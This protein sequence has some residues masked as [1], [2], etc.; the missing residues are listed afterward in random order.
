[1]NTNLDV[2]VI[3]NFS[4]TELTDF[5]NQLIEENFSSLVHLLYKIDVS[6]KQLK[7][8]LSSH[9][10]EN[11][12]KLIAALIMKRLKQKQETKLSFKQENDI[13]EDEKW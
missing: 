10:N 9:P 3:E 6:E 1:M 7:D 8:V 11:A 12:G 13:A 4:V 5:I 2:S